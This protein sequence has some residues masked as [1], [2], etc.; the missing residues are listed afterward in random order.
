MLFNTNHHIRT[1]LD[2]K[3]IEFDEQNFSN[4]V[5][6]TNFLKDFFE[7][8]F[9]SQFSAQI[10]LKNDFFKEINFNVTVLK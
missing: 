9:R 8:H 2:L 10:L 6:L 7:A 4:L 1:H 5:F 3:K